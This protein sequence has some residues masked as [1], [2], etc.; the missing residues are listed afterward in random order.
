[1]LPSDVFA[2]SAFRAGDWVEVRS[3]EEVL[4]TLDADGCLEGLP[5]QPEMFA[6]CGQRLRVWKGAHKTCD[7]IN[8]TGGR[9]MSRAVHLEGVRC[10]G[11][12]HGGCQA[13]CLLFWKDAWLKRAESESSAAGLDVIAMSARASPAAP[14]PGSEAADTVWRCQTTALFGATSPLPWWQLSQYIADVR[15][16]NFGAWHMARILFA[17]AYRRLVYVGIGYGALIRLYNAF[18]K[19]RGGKPFAI[20]DGLLPAGVRTPS[21]SLALQPGE[22][23]RVRS[24]DDIRATLGPDKKNRG[25]LFDPE[26]VQFCGESR[27]VE[28]IVTRIIDERSGRMMQMK[29]PCIVLKDAY[30]RGE[31]TPRRL[32]CPRAIDSYWHEIW[33][34]RGGA[35]GSQPS[36]TA[37]ER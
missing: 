9:R 21:L 25:L 30:C 3:R 31:C 6:L 29:S 23:V 17:A 26:M 15:S 37:P 16:G 28:R 10:D 35:P 27:Q 20:A 12:A 18:Q 5:F 8:K 4:A 19:M 7:T 24:A 13:R 14:D 1:M 33:L 34:E 32:G 36:I 22:W 2:A 11:A